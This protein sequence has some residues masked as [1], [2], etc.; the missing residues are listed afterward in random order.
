MGGVILAGGA[1][2]RLGGIDKPMITVGGTTL[3][4]RAIDALGAADPVVVVGPRR[5]QRTEPRTG[6]LWTREEP[7]GSGPV[8]A[9]TAGLLLVPNEF[10]AVLAAD[11]SGITSQT[12][13]RLTAAASGA[14]AGAVL[15]D[16]AGYRQWLIGVWRRTALWAR[17]PTEPAHASLRRTLG[18]GPVVE[19]A[20]SP[21]EADDVDTIDDLRR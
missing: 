20:A 13:E 1:A 16:R 9:L 4:E 5:P 14:S 15:V 17:L 10:V 7:P 2:A 6:L 8:A 18:A 12:V 21:G 19:V 11:L 3:L